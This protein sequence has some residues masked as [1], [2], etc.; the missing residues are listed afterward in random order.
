MQRLGISWVY[1]RSGTVEMRPTIIHVQT[2]NENE[3]P[4]LDPYFGTQT[5]PS[6][7]SHSSR[8]PVRPILM[9]QSIHGHTNRLQAMHRH[10][11]VI[12]ISVWL[13][14]QSERDPPTRNI[15]TETDRCP[16]CIEDPA[17]VRLVVALFP[18]ASI[19]LRTDIRTSCDMCPLAERRHS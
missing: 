17:I 13:V 19:T 12:Q 5:T 2:H 1:Q 6:T 8:S 18:H 9:A 14:E 11:A 10:A 3:S 4:N 16:R 7:G 15:S